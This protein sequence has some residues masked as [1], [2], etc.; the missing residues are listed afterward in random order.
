MWKLFGKILVALGILAGA[1]TASAEQNAYDFEFLSIDKK[2][3]PLSQYRGKLMLVV[4]T[5][6]ECG[7][8]GQ[9]EGLQTLWERYKDRG[10]VVIGVPSNNF[11]S[12]EP[13]SCE[14]ILQFTRKKYGITFPLTDKV[15]VRGSDAHPFYAWANDQ[16]GFMG[17]PRWNFHKYLI[18]TKGQ[19][20]DWWS[21]TSGPLSDD[22]IEEI[23]ENLPKP[24]QK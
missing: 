9:Y 3:M 16:A 17:V 23:E 22:I 15:S 6:S 8:V 5:A 10:L 21:S 14:E 13:R 2:P 20:I 18:G 11:G 4:N 7:F 19:L 1:G 12:Q 24:K